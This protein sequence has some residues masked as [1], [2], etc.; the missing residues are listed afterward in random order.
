MSVNNQVE[1]TILAIKGI[2]FDLD[3]TLV[4]TTGLIIDSFHYTIEMVLGRTT[5]QEEILS[6]WGMTLRDSMYAYSPEKR[7]EL[8]QV[9]RHYNETMHDKLIKPFPKV[10]ETLHELSQLGI[11]CAIVT[12]KMT[13]TAKRGLEI[14]NLHTYVEDIIGM[15]KCQHHKPHPEPVLNGLAA[16][17]LA[18]HECLM[19]GDSVQDLQ[20][21]H[22]AGVPAV[23]VA[24][25]LLY[26]SGTLT[27]QAQPD[28]IIQNM[29][30]LL[31]IIKG[32]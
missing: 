22:N 24:W 21:A 9:Y 29:P 17:N 16:L 2:L 31:K 3:G 25:S 12:S 23:G 1:V 18:A 32:E 6:Y 27:S 15:D 11:K 19:V 5:S 4:D 30:D 20:A 10:Q 26:P 7:E 28:Y 8:I 13:H 14:F